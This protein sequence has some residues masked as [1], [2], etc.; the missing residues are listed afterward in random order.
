MNFNYKYLVII[1]L[2]IGVIY[3]NIRIKESF[4]NTQD[5]LKIDK[6]N[7]SLCMIDFNEY[8]KHIYPLQNKISSE[9]KNFI[10]KWIKK[11]GYR[12]IQNDKHISSYM[13]GFTIDKKGKINRSRFGIG[14]LSFYRDFKDDCQMLLRQMNIDLNEPKGFLW[15]FMAWDIEKKILK[16]YFKNKENTN[17]I[18]HVYQLDRDDNNEIK[19]ATK[20]FIKKYLV[21]KDTN[22][23]FLDKRKVTQINSEHLPIKLIKKYPKSRF[24]INDMFNK[25]WDL[26]TYSDYDNKLTLYFD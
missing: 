22:I 1:L 20:L 18:S 7:N 17:I 14:T 23:M 3:Y 24:I 11:I 5:F 10:V 12:D 16:V 2:I 21:N 19:K 15:Y 13:F 9:E 4:F 6:T 26:Y 25:G 8:N